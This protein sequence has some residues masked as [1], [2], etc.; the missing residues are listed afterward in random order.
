MKVSVEISDM[1]LR[2]V[3]RVSGDKRKGPAIRSLAMEALQLR[4][5][6]AMTEKFATGAWSVTLPGAIGKG[7]DRSA[8][9]R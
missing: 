1:E 9:P 6:R 5:R 7:K 8:W 2:D 4:K 3:Q